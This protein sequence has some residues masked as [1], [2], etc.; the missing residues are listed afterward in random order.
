MKTLPLGIAL[1]VLLAGTTAHAR[2][3]TLASG[4]IP[5]SFMAADTLLPAGHYEFDRAMDGVLAIVN[6]RTHQRVVVTVIDRDARWPAEKT[7]LRFH[8]YETRYF[9][10]EIS[11]VGEVQMTEL[12]R[13]AAE[14]ALA[15]N[16]KP[17]P[18]LV[19]SK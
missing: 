7:V 19:A 12:R 8:A 11:V 3:E 15:L 10:S 2:P 9:L 5:F 16:T 14:R 17:T 4:Y 13:G 6:T 1:V 18:P